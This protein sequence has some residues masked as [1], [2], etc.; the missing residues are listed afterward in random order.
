MTETEQLLLDSLEQIRNIAATIPAVAKQK[1]AQEH[2]L[3]LGRQALVPSQQFTDFLMEMHEHSNGHHNHFQ[4][5]AN[6]WARQQAAEIEQLRER[7]QVLVEA[8]RSEPT[9]LIHKWRVLEIIND[10]AALANTQ[11]APSQSVMTGQ[12]DELISKLCNVRA[13]ASERLPKVDVD[14]IDEAI[15]VLT[16]INNTALLQP[17]TKQQIDAIVQEHMPE[18][19]SPE[20]NPVRKLAAYRSLVHAGWAAAHGI[21]K[22]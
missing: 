2:F 13:I 12:F 11:P 22:D 17:L 21:K 14:T 20:G 1:V 10:S 15:G 6:E 7:E 8:L 5:A 4:V 9:E 16:G 19:N 18:I 3:S